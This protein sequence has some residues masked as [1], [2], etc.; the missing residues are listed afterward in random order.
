MVSL[1]LH[2]DEAWNNSLC[3][4]FI[5]QTLSPWKEMSSS[6]QTPCDLRQQVRSSPREAVSKQKQWQRGNAT[7]K[8][9][10]SKPCT[11]KD[12]PQPCNEAQL[13]FA[14]SREH[15][16]TC[17]K[18]S[19]SSSFQ[20]QP[21]I[22][23]CKRGIIVIRPHP[24]LQLPRWEKCHEVRQNEGCPEGFESHSLLARLRQNTR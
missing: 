13:V 24:H 18:C 14:K 12:Q 15:M 3:S 2:I 19:S 9:F 4:L 21:R 10:G 23:T 22:W 7:T 16:A 17:H 5:V 1:L 6:I 20:M 11:C 8:Q